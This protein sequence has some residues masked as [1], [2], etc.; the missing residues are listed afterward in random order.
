[1]PDPGDKKTSDAGSASASLKLQRILVF[2]T[3]KI[4]NTLSEL[5]L[6]VYLGS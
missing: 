5:V 1:M 4:G 2:L 3:Q 6:D